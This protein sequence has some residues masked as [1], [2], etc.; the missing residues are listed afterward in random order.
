MAYELNILAH[1]QVGEM[2]YQCDSAT[3]AH[4]ATTVVDKHV[5]KFHLSFSPSQAC[6]TIPKARLPGLK[7]PNAQVHCQFMSKLKSCLADRV[8]VNNR[9]HQMLKEKLQ[10]HSINLS[11]NVHPLEGIAS[12]AM[13]RLADFDKIIELTGRTGKDR[14]AVSF[15]YNL[16][17]LKRMQVFIEDVCDRSAAEHVAYPASR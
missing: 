1:L 15:L 9:V 8:P 11:C 16:S 6:Y 14:I 2:L 10:I 13:K 5:V 7:L 4:D 12:D 3:I 17:K